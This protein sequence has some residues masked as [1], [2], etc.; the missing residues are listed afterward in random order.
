MKIAGQL[1]EVTNLVQFA[2]S[3]IINANNPKE[4]T[5]K[6]AAGIRLHLATAIPGFG[7]S[8]FPG[9]S[10][11]T[12]SSATG[13][14]TFNV[15][16]EQINQLNTNKMVYIVGYRNAGS[17]NVAGTTITLYEPV[18]RSALFDI[19]KYNKNTLNLYYA[20]YNV[21][22]ESGITQTQVDEQIKAAKSKFKDLDKLSATIQN[23]KVSVKGSGRGAD[24]KFNIELSPST[25]F[26]LKR[27][28]TGKVKDMDIDLP[29]P[30]IIVGIC[31]SEDEI[32]K[33]IEAGISTL[34]KEVN[35]TIEKTIIDQVAQQ[36]GQPRSLVENIFKTFASVTFSKLSYPIVE[37]KTI[38]VPLGG[39]ITISIRGVVPTLS[40]GFPRNIS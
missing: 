15:S 33:E 14:F 28:L 9:L 39:S 24:I 31:V 23:G 36:T 30:D 34:I 35:A 12:Y 37:Q 1:F 38:K 40:I 3:Y 2:P 19:T 10:I 17:V 13:A 21:P 25:S 22:N 5:F 11:K 20:P 16:A 18:Y 27:F 7:G 32:E 26:D 8:F 6:S 4:G 29:G